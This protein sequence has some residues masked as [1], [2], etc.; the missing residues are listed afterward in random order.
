MVG[1]A[2]SAALLV[3]EAIQPMQSVLLFSAATV[4]GLLPDI[5]A[6]HSTPLQIAFGLVSLMVSFFLLFRLS[7][8]LSLAELMVICLGAY[9]V[10]QQ[11]AFRLF[12]R[13]TA[14]RGIWH[15]LP[16]AALFGLLTVMLLS[17]GFDYDGRM[18][19]LA[20]L[21]LTAGYV[22]HLLLDEFYSLNLFGIG[23][24]KRSLGSAFKLYSS[25]LPITI[26][27]YSAL[28]LAIHM[29][30]PWS[31]AMGPAF[32]QATLE[33]LQGRLLPAEGWFS[34]FWDPAP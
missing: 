13:S 34:P 31:D 19:W 17:Y 14:H 26:G 9:L 33:A 12:T 16:A 28:G 15:S 3:S 8:Q 10:L 6:D 20:G 25:N 11:V 24:A 27:I 5:D 1:G 4:G 18:A 21:F 30:P 32:L 2:A 29:A 7:K 23:G 22:T